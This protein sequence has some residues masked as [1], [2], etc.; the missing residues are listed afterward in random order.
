MIE[1]R[2]HVIGFEDLNIDN[3]YLFCGYYEDEKPVLSKDFKEAEVYDIDSAIDVQQSL[4]A[5][6]RNYTWRIIITDVSLFGS[7]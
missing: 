3:P 4:D 5:E 2:F 6:Y 7:C 1:R